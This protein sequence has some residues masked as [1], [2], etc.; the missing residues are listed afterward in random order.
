MEWS[1]LQKAIYEKVEKSKK[2]LMVR[3]VA[4]SGKSTTLF[5]IA[6]R[7]GNNILFLAFNKSIADYGEKKMGKKVDCRTFHS[8]GLKTLTAYTGKFP[9]KNDKKVW[10]VVRKRYNRFDYRGE[11]Y[12]GSVVN[13][14]IKRV[15]DLGMMS[16]EED[17]LMDFLEDNP[18]WS[19]EPKTAQHE[20]SWVFSNLRQ[21]INL[22]R[23]LD[24][25]LDT[26]DFNDM[27]RLPCIHNMTLKLEKIPKTVLVDEAQDMNPYQIHLIMQLLKR[28]VRTICVGDPN[29]AIYAFRGSNANS[30]DV[31]RDMTDAEELP[32]SVTYRCKS[33]IVDF[34]NDTISTSDMEAFNTGGN[35]DFLYKEDV[36]SYIID[37]DIQ[38]IVGAKNRSLLELWIM[39]AKQRIGSSLKGTGIAEQLRNII[40]DFKPKSLEH[41]L[42]DM[43][44]AINDAMVYDEEEEKEICTL[45]ES[46]VELMRCIQ[47]LVEAFGVT[48]LNGLEYSL[49]DMEKN[50]KISIHTIHSAKGLEDEK[51]LVLQDWFP[52]DQL[53]NMKYVAY[54]RGSDGLFCVE[55]W[56][57]EEQVDPNDLDELDPE[58]ISQ[59]AF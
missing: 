38:L 56:M 35:V 47:A 46:T 31:L 14:V 8:F 15:R 45:P 30:M 54:T 10:D 39:L 18:V 40:K 20:K 6:K 43:S 27:V 42:R 53:T 28:G 3:A 16:Y 25:D 59:D 32:L 37:H 57:K 34:V 26:I 19:R 12:P 5:E 50:S 9:E 4:G 55:D 17:D 11:W 24:N 22:I 2:N 51:V 33:N 36:I 52:N 41:L 48:D 29:Q 13:K 21:I 1:S 23:D 7:A 58:F 49:K 44:E